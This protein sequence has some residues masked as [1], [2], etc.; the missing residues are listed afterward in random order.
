MSTTTTTANAIT[1]N[2]LLTG[3]LIVT[4]TS[5]AALNGTYKCDGHMFSAL[6]A[7]ADSLA[8]NNGTF[9]DGSTSVNWPDWSGASHTFTEAQFRTLIN[10]I[11][12]FVV[13]CAQYA[14]GITSTP[15]LNTATIP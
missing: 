10:A 3:G 12:L 9:V 1:A 6:Q 7:E 13:Q 15:P 11:N 8:L 14:A 4:S 5:T 2:H